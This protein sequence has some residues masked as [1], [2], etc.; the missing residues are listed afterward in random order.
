M[1]VPHFQEARVIY[2]LGSVRMFERPQGY[3]SKAQRGGHISP[4]AGNSE[5]DPKITLPIFIIALH[6]FYIK[7]NPGWA[8]HLWEADLIDRYI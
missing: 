6:D 8:S 4:P 2:P 1:D 3:R 7:N 5:H